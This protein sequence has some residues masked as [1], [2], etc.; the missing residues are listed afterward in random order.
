[1]Y[2]MIICQDCLRNA[3]VLWQ[4]PQKHFETE[5]KV[6]AF[7]FIARLSE[8]RSLPTADSGTF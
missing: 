1:M 7:V 2:L 8:P 5:I 3:I 4:V 6:S